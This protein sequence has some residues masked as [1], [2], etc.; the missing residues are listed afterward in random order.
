MEEPILD[1]PKV[2]IQKVSA[3]ST[4]RDA[5]TSRSSKKGVRIDKKV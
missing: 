5:S 4:N 1:L 3:R 2:E